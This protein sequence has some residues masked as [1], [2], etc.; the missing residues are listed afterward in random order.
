MME[1]FQLYQILLKY[2]YFILFFFT[3]MM[4]V[5]IF[6]VG[7]VVFLKNLF[8]SSATISTSEP[9]IR[10]DAVFFSQIY[11]YKL[12]YQDLVSSQLLAQFMVVNQTFEA[13][14]FVTMGRPTNSRRTVVLLP[15]FWGQDLLWRKPPWKP[16]WRKRQFGDICVMI[17]S[18]YLWRRNS[19]GF[20]PYKQH[21]IS[22][23]TKTNKI[24]FFMRVSINL[25][26]VRCNRW[27]AAYDFR[28]RY[29]YFISK[30]KDDSQARKSHKVD[31]DDKV[32]E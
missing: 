30:K 23:T 9:M 13:N 18:N 10:C 3:F 17:I 5:V 28:M 24:S 4:M 29:R 25:K 32:F 12:R 26:G 2:I 11:N 1:D 6:F 19:R 16:P 7:D 21:W 22:S 31:R 27:I 15:K 8:H 20:I 14:Q